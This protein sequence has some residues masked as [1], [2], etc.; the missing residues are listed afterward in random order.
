MTR[1]WTEHSDLAIGGVQIAPGTQ[2]QIELPLPPLYVTSKIS[3]PVHVLRGKKPGPVLFVSAAV[4]GDEMNGTE[5]IRRLLNKPGLKRLNG[6]LIAVP[7]VNVYGVITRSRYLPDRRDL[8]R[9]FPGSET[10]S[11]AARLA[12]MFINEIVA[13]ATHGID[14]HTGAI[15]RTNLPQIRGNLDDDETRELAEVFNVPVLLNSAIIAGSLRQAA[16]DYDIPVLIYEAGEALRYDEVCIRAGVKGIV[17]VMRKLGM[18]SSRSK[19]QAPV[20]PITARSSS[21]LRAEYS[22]LFRKVAP[23]GGRVKRGDVVGYI[24]D[25]FSGEAGEVIATHN[26]IVIGCIQTMLVHEG[27]ALFHIARFE[28]VQEVAETVDQF[29][30]DL[31]PEPVE[32]VYEPP[33]V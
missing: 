28:D 23:L 12:D 29:Q 3:M 33:I 6:T 17:N 21:W 7:V 30:S 24:D 10:G 26:G 19:R 20:E 15:N 2:T 32:N 13:K 31:S 11:L 18:L 25:P 1:E 8:N 4:H 14:L 5:I 27:E 16:A 22:G 9:C